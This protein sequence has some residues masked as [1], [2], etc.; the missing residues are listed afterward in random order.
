[1]QEMPEQ[2][3]AIRH[4]KWNSR[5]RCGS[6]SRNF[7]F[8][9]IAFRIP[10]RYRHHY[11]LQG[12]TSRWNLTLF[13]FIFRIRKYTR[14]R[15]A[16][17]SASATARKSRCFCH[18]TYEKHKKEHSQSIIKDSLTQ[19]IHRKWISLCF[20]HVHYTYSLH[21]LCV[22]YHQASGLACCKPRGY[23]KKV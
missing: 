11:D 15:G 8:A 20:V 17:K 13:Y 22:F 4:P 5:P 18:E 12:P 7:A 16:T 1:M 9:A 2:L 21:V 23:G 10:S 19:R 3:Q 14:F 6:A